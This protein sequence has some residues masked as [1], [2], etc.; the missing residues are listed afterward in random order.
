MPEETEIKTT[1]KERIK[2]SD[3]FTYS[4]LLLFT[5][6]AMVMSVFNSIYGIVDGYFVSNFCGSTALA[7]VNLIFPP[8]MI[9]SSFAFMLGGGGAALVGKV[10]GEKDNERANAYFSL[11]TYA[12][13][14]IGVVFSVG[15]F[16]MC[17]WISRA[18]GATGQLYS[19]CLIY[20]RILIAGGI[21]Y[22]LQFHFHI[23]FITAE[24]PK[25]G[26][27]FTIGAG[28]SNMIMDLLF[29]GIF[30]WGL[31]GA[32][33]ATVLAQVIGG[34][35]PLVYFILPNDSLLR[36]GKTYMSWFCIGRSLYN[37]ISEFLGSI[38]ANLVSLVTNYELLKYAGADGVAA[39]G[40][41]MYFS[42]IFTS[43][44]F[45]YCT[46]SS[47]IISYHY[48]AQNWDE[49]KNMLRKSFMIEMVGCIIACGLNIVLARPCT[50]IYVGYDP[51]L[52]N[53]TVH[54]FIIYSLSYI[55]MGFGYFSSV[56]FTALNN[57][58]VAGIVQFI[59]IFVLQVGLTLLMGELFGTEGLWWAMVLAQTIGFVVACVAIW[60][61][62][63]RYHYL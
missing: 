33:L 8:I 19:D 29:V 1:K 54:A 39:Y 60:V 3:H 58:L 12:T 14:V 20:G 52:V 30:K 57:G 7:A 11:I 49:L 44:I 63:D 55:G 13:V 10:L 24:K 4:R 56:L 37:G 32:A 42:W 17:P 31:V 47:P 15:L 28:C 61:C 46:G 51:D 59:R 62:R 36:L 45:G 34:I 53:F 40:V 16:L 21:P 5:W 23:F 6:P 41:I 48:G 2:L 27:W 35:G 25:L 26:L 18:L 50:V 38:S 43:F 22:L 9:A